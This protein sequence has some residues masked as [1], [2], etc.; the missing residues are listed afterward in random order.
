MYIYTRLTGK[1]YVIRVKRDSSFFQ[2]NFR[3][4]FIERNL[5][6]IVDIRAD[7]GDSHTF[8]RYYNWQGMRTMAVNRTA[9]TAESRDA[10]KRLGSHTYPEVSLTTLMQGGVTVA[11][12]QP[13]S[14]ANQHAEENSRRALEED[15]ARVAQ[16]IHDH[17][18][19]LL[20][21]LRTRLQSAT[22]S[23]AG[24]PRGD[25]PSAARDAALG[26]LAA[27]GTIWQ[28]L[29]DATRQLQSDLRP[30][31]LDSL[32]LAAALDALKQTFAGAGLIVTLHAEGLADRRFDAALETTAYWI[33][34][35]SLTNVLRHSGADKA[36]VSANVVQ[37]DL[38]ETVHLVI[39]DGG[40]GFAVGPIGNT[41]GLTAMYDRAALIG[42]T[43]VID[44][45]PGRGTRIV[46]KLP[47]GA[48]PSDT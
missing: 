10:L 9:E 46:A 8:V 40:K 34:Q 21:L 27:A 7:S 45:V 2:T 43:V 5:P 19:F 38:G 44:S 30:A 12:N 13:S 20:M 33:T 17:L 29:Y 15:R 26:E 6:I 18:G 42:G 22:E 4:P 31:P 3:Q 47:S 24:I 35:H 14:G 28:Q 48:Q 11:D 39:E 32:G 36:T 23:I 1:Q 37:S 25:A 16:W 41:F